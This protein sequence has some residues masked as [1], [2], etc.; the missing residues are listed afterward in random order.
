MFKQQEILGDDSS[1]KVRP[2]KADLIS[3]SRLRTVSY[4]DKED[5]IHWD[6]PAAMFCQNHMTCLPQCTTGLSIL[7]FVDERGITPPSAVLMDPHRLHPLTTSPSCFPI[8]TTS[9]IHS[10]NSL[11]TSSGF[12]NK[13]QWF[14]SISLLVNLG[15]K[16]LSPR[17]TIALASSDFN[18][19]S[20]FART[21]NTSCS[22]RGGCSTSPNRKK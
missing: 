22:T 8:K 10:P 3:N 5:Q 12:S 11:F 1:L 2:I 20:L 18:A 7:V 9:S 15:S 21:N 13:T 17:P 16:A 14:P 4:R 19:P 6:H